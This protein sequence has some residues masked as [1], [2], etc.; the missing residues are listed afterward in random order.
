MSFQAI[1][2]PTIF[3]DVITVPEESLIYSLVYLIETIVTLPLTPPTLVELRFRDQ[4]ELP[5]HTPS[6]QV[7][8]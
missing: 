3:E 2:V 6:I 1:L 4:A 7:I 5:E 8:E